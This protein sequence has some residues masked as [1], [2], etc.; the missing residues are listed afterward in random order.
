MLD[1]TERQGCDQGFRGATPHGIMFLDMQEKTFFTCI[2]VTNCDCEIA[3]LSVSVVGKIFR[4]EGILQLFC[5]SGLQTVM[6][7]DCTDTVRV[8][9][10]T[11]PLRMISCWSWTSLSDGVAD[12][13]GCLT[14]EERDSVPHGIIGLPCV[15]MASFFFFPST[16]CFF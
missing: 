10:P 16:K 9:L 13:Q 5:E 6:E 7:G 12:L 14:C 15:I 11:V 3:S 2:T 1:A 8:D 4:S